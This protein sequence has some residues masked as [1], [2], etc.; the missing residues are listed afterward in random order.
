MSTDNSSWTVPLP[1]ADLPPDSKLRENDLPEVISE[2]MGHP[3]A[4]VTLSRNDWLH[5]KLGQ[6]FNHFG[7]SALAVLVQD[8]YTYLNIDPSTSCEGSWQEGWVI[9][10]LPNA[11]LG[12]ALE[13]LDAWLTTAATEP[14][15]WAEIFDEGYNAESIANDLESSEDLRNEG[16]SGVDGDC[17]HY[18]FSFLKTLR[19][20]LISARENSLALVHA[21]YVYL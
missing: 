17:P 15:L 12:P 3:D 16:A 7:G 11:K 1:E 9:T 13:E 6:A 18:L 5:W 20:A 8:P 19:A 14:Q 10:A 21:R 4:I 2:A